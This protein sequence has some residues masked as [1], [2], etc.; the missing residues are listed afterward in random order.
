MSALLQRAIRLLARREHTRAELVVKLSAYGNEA[1]IEAALN[2]LRARGL[3]SDARFVDAY[4]RTHAPRLGVA[5][6]RQSLR[7]K[8]VASELIEAQLPEASGELERARAVWQ[9]KYPIAPHDRKEWLRQARF[10]QSRGF[11]PDIVVRLLKEVDA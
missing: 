11:S 6:L 7:R 8:G 1:D 2:E 3:Q 10:L 9:R 5:R 4:L